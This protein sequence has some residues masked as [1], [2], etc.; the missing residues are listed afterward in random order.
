VS[1]PPVFHNDATVSGFAPTFY[2]TPAEFA[3]FPAYMRQI[4]ACARAYGICKIVPPAAVSNAAEA[5][6]R[7]RRLTVRRPLRQTARAV[8]PGH[9]GVSLRWLGD[10]SVDELL[11]KAAPRAPRELAPADAAGEARGAHDAKVE[12]RFWSEI[13]HGPAIYGA[14]MPGSLFDADAP[15]NLETLDNLLQSLPRIAGVNEPY[16]YVGTWRSLFAWHVEDKDLYSI[17]YLHCG[18]PKA[19]YAVGPDLAD[20]V[21]GYCQAF[22][23][24]ERDACPEFLRHKACMIDP[25]EFAKHQIVVQRAVQRPGEF[26]V[27]FPRAYHAGFNHG[28]NCAEACN[29]A[30][31]SW[32]EIGAKARV[33]AC[34]RDAV[35]VDVDYLREVARR[36]SPR[37]DGRCYPMTKPPPPP[38]HL[39]PPRN[40]PLASAATSRTPSV[41][42]LDSS[43]DDDDDNR[44]NKSGRMKNKRDDDDDAAATLPLVPLVS[45]ADTIVLRDAAPVRVPKRSAVLMQP[46]S[47]AKRKII[48]TS[49]N[50]SNAR[51]LSDEDRARARERADKLAKVSL[52]FAVKTADFVVSVVCLGT[53]TPRR[54]FHTEHAIYPIGYVATCAFHDKPDALFICEVLS[55]AGEAKFQIVPSHAP[56]RAVV[57]GSPSAAW[58]N[59]MD[60]KK[61][62]GA[63]GEA[64]FGLSLLPVRRVLELLPNVEQLGRYAA[65]TRADE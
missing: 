56:T 4:D 46:T 65:L 44:D 15:W 38:L 27:T 25:A 40:A 64:L 34:N 19:W 39:S 12:R 5:A 1:A 17:N 43:D 16:L 35:T 53:V 30:L 55:D 23:V 2:P 45:D 60:K 22:F 42:V 58:A 62:K 50:A 9:Y 33:C 26:I 52:P 14:D 36:L 3:S 63:D 8:A 31:E 7:V 11:A 10:M 21:E 59:L 48:T 6:A 51:E 61:A 13:A 32:L 20:C 54:G 37:S 47:R 29:F 57:A 41:I 24:D 28:F 18:A 49:S